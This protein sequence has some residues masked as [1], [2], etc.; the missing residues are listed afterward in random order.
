MTGGAGKLAD[1]QR[2]GTI[3]GLAEAYKYIECFYGGSLLWS[4]RQTLWHHEMGLQTRAMVI[5]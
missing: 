5:L 3:A 1:V 4:L 2:Q